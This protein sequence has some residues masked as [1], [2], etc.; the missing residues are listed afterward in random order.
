MSG[1]CVQRRKQQERMNDLLFYPDADADINNLKY[2]LFSIKPYSRY[3]RWG[4]MRSLKRAIKLI[5]KDNKNRIW[6]D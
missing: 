1:A 3:Y 5:E 2:M 4:M 6:E